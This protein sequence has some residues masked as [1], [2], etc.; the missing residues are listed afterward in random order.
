MYFLLAFL[1]NITIFAFFDCLGIRRCVVHFG[2]SLA[3]C[4]I[5]GS[6][7]AFRVSML[8]LISHFSFYSASHDIIGGTS[9]GYVC[10]VTAWSLSY[11]YE[12]NNYTRVMI[13]S[14]T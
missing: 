2:H 11:N 6:S 10:I 8:M 12:Y 14:S 7:P 5:L 9:S 4:F 3:S 1:N 13:L